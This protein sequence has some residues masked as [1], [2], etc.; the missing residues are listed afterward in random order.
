MLKAVK[1]KGTSMR[2]FL[3][4]GDLVFYEECLSSLKLGD[5]ILYKYSDNLYIHRIIG[6]EKEKI[7]ISND[8]DMETHFI[9]KK[10]VLG[11]VCSFFNGYPGYLAHIIIK[12]IRFLKRKLR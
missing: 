7:S 2:P 1:L 6:F 11:R 9:E 5:M 8:D 10:D 3:K 12:N 4:D